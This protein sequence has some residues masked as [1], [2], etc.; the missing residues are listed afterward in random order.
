MKLYIKK[1]IN[2]LH[3][4]QNI[5]EFCKLSDLSYD[6]VKEELG[7]FSRTTKHSYETSFK[8]FKEYLWQLQD[9]NDGL[10]IW[11]EGRKL[12]ESIN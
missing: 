4:E 9:K 5:E 10:K 3:L 7:Y 8:I 11:I 12:S 2:D 6:I 1:A